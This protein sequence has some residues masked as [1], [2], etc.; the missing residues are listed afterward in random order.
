M[1]IANGE[2][3]KNFEGLIGKVT[4]FYSIKLSQRVQIAASRSIRYIGGMND[5]C[6]AEKKM[7]FN[8]HR[9]FLG[10]FLAN[11]HTSE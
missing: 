6:C 11:N 3:N 4:C 7:G 5:S 1:L 9:V 2:I 8:C 10:D